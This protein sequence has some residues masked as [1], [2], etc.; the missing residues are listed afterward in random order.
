LTLAVQIDAGCRRLLWIGK[1]HTEKTLQEFFDLLGDKLR[2][3]LRYVCSDMWAAY[4]KVIAE[5]AGYAWHVL[6][7]F[8]VMANM[9]KAIDE[10]RREQA[11]QLSSSRSPRNRGKDGR[12]QR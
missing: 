4:L 6:D 5:R 3:T 12:Q 2:P 10:V 8:H 7:R 11:R 1:G 9:N